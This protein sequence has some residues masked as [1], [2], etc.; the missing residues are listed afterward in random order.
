MRELIERVFRPAFDNPV[1]AQRHDSAVLPPL[2]GRLALTNDGYVVRP[3]FF[4][5]GDIGTL[6]VNGTVNDLAMA[7]AVPEYLTASFILEEGFEIAALRRIV[8]SMATAAA[9]ARVSIVTGDTKVV[10]RGHGDGVYVVTS[11]V[12]RVPDGVD[13][14]PT[15][16]EPG[17]AIL[18][19]GDLGRH[20]IAVLSV[21]EGLAFGTELESDC[22]ELSSVVQALIQGGVVPHCLRDLTRGGLAAALCELALDAD[23]E[24]ELD[25][26][27]IPIS[28]AV[29]GA[30]ELLGLDPLYVACE[31]RFVA[32]VPEDQAERAESLMR[33]AGAAPGRIGRVRG[34]SARERGSVELSSA[35]GGTR[36]VELFYGEQLPRIC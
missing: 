33:G 25:E 17:D 14:G 7:G 2:P 20:G 35:F 19:S 31:G 1:L 10:D 26:R 4:P 34:H 8:A 13:I 24:I 6:A 3:L 12:G 18:V 9:G 28:D 30:S 22:A 23:L 16:V 29:R 5:G 36:L 32:F 11:G 21:R 27:R 15:R